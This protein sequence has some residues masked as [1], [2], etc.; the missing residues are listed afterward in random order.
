MVLPGIQA[1]FGFQL[2]VVFNLTF[3]EKF[4]TTKRGLH[5]TD[6]I[7]VA[8]AM[9]MVPVAYHQQRD[10]QSISETLSSL[11]RDSFFLIAR[12]MTNSLA[13]SLVLATL[14]VSVFLIF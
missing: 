11:P 12:V 13:P 7:I 14:L 3:S 2:I 1:L 8:I 5:L 9:V 10:P 6:L 4:S